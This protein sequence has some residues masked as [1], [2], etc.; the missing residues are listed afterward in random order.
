M[1]QKSI[2][3]I[4]AIIV[5][6]TVAICLGVLFLADW[7]PFQSPNSI[8]T[9]LVVSDLSTA[10]STAD[11]GCTVTSNVNLRA[12]PGTNY[13]PPL[14]VL[15]ADSRFRPTAR[16]A[17]NQ[18]LQGQHEASGQTGWVYVAYLDC[19]IEI[20]SLALGQVPS[21]PTAG[22]TSTA[23]VTPSPLPTRTPT[24]QTATATAVVACPFE[25]NTPFNAHWQ[26]YKIQLGCPTTQTVT[27][28]LFVEQEFETGQMFWIAEL[29]W[30][31]VSLDGDN[32]RWV[33]FQNEAAFDALFNPN[34]EG[35][36][37]Q[38]RR[39]PG[40]GQ[41]QP[42]R[43]FGAIW[44]GQFKGIDFQAAL[45]FATELEHGQ[46]DNQFLAFEHGYMLQA[47]DG[48]THIFFLETVDTGHTIVR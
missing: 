43:G 9:P 1:S 32:G 42:I 29:D 19:G 17:D 25:P 2:F 41:I 26:R 34:H 45:G 30:F 12:G 23:T 27:K 18:W 5:L 24:P 28:G 15:P 33:T 31:F 37:C 35:V 22:T 4:A 16:T 48:R 44:C 36:S 7:S 13:E 8:A 39:T 38:P 10:T 11:R 3:I 40:P 47:S 6:A 20:T 14:A 21:T 46:L